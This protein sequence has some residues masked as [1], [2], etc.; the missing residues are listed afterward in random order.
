MVIITKMKVII[1]EMIVVVVVKSCNSLEIPNLY[2]ST[3]IIR[4]IKSRRM[5]WAGHIARIGRRRMHI[6]YRWESQRERD[7]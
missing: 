1:Y 3:S 5:R 6:G 2:S 7:H 4:M